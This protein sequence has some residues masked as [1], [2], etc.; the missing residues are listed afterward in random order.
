M[1]KVMPVKRFAL[2]KKLLVLLL[3]LLFEMQR[4]GL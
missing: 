3:N 2:T 1:A 4:C